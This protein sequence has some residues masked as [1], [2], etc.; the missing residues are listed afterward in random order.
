MHVSIYFSSTI[1]S[2][3]FKF[4]SSMV[5]KRLAFKLKCPMIAKY[6]SDIKDLEQKS[7]NVNFLKNIFIIL[8]I[9]HTHVCAYVHACAC[10]CIWTWTY[11]HEC[12]CPWRTE[13]LDPPGAQYK[14]LWVATCGCWDPHLG[15]LN[16]WA[17]SPSPNHS[18]PKEVPKVAYACKGW[19]RGI[20]MSS[21]PAWATR[22]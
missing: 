6:I 13:M 8:K 19:D 4:W 2:M 5:N 22:W 18:I 1:M 15:P 9:V 20:T 12:R 14:R 3:K 11:S 7:R 21:K 10:M 16:Q 17:I